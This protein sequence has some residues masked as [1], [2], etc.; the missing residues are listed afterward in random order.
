MFFK[1][2]KVRKYARTGFMKIIV[3]RSLKDYDYWKKLVSTGKEVRKQNGSNGA[4]VYRSAKNPNEVYLVFDWD[5]QK[6]FLNYF[7]LPDVKKSLA[8]TGGTEIIEVS[9]SFNLDA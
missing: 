7:N 1:K 2:L 6:S 4:N 3:K 8:E 9:E 5:D